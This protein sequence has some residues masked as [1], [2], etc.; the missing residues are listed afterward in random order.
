MPPPRGVGLIGLG[1][2][3]GLIAQRLLSS[4]Q[5]L[6]VHDSNVQAAAALEAHG[7]V[8]RSSPRE[9]AEGAHTVLLSLP[10]PEIVRAVALG[11]DG[12]AAGSAI[13]VCIDLSTTG[14]VVSAEIASELGAHGI[15]F[16]DAPVSGGVSGA[17]QGTLTVMAACSH[18]EL[19]EVRPLLDMIASRVLHVGEQPGMGQLA[20]V[21]NNL[22]SATA[23]AVTAE[24]L[25]LGVK[26]GLDAETLLEVFNASSGR[27]SATVQKFPGSVLPRTFDFGFALSL[28][29][30]DVQLCLGAASSAGVP[31]PVGESV[32]AELSQAR[33]QLGDSA[34]CTEL[35][36]IVE[37]RAGTRIGADGAPGA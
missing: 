31:M 7:A 25:A 12:L 3:G 16:V 8:V 35:V 5:P 17:E 26:S 20:K 13:R 15:A 2:M 32:G 10:S 30:K 34:D 4:G 19:E 22:M 36:K 28:M 23:L 14:P 37:H 24:A 29:D 1:A 27:N 21:L 9:V 18:G 6:L 11:P 33:A